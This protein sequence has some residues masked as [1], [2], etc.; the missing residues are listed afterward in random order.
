MSHLLVL[1]GAATLFFGATRKLI[2]VMLETPPQG[3]QAELLGLMLVLTGDSAIALGS[4]LI[5]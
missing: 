2:H 5:A 3:V 1:L 4:D